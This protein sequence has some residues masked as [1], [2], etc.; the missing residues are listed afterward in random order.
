LCAEDALEPGFFDE[1]VEML[2]RDYDTIVAIV[3]YD[4]TG[5]VASIYQGGA[6]KEKMGEYQ[7]YYYRLNVFAHAVQRYHLEN[8]TTS[9]NCCVRT[10]AMRATAQ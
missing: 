8:I 7:G 9:S 1:C 10:V 4:G 3:D 5:N 2:I 6:G